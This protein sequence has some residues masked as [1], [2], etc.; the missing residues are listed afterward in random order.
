MQYISCFSDSLLHKETNNLVESFNSIVCKLVNGKRVNLC[1][2]NQYDTRVAYAIIQHNSQ[3][4]LMQIYV[5]MGKSVPPNVVELMH[6]RKLKIARTKQSRAENGRKRRHVFSKIDQNYGIMCEKPDLTEDQ[7]A[8]ARD[9][10]FLE[11]KE[12]QQNRVKIESDT[13]EQSQ[14]DLWETLRRKLLTASN[15][16]RICR[17]RPHTS[18]AATVKSLLFPSL[19]DNV[20]MTYGR[21]CE[22]IARKEI[23]IVTKLEIKPCG[24]F[25]DS[26]D[27]RF[28]ASPDGIID[29]DG[30]VEIKNPHR[31]QNLTAKEA[32]EKY[33][34][35]NFIDKK[36][37]GM[38]TTN[39]WYYQVQGQLHVTERNY[40]IFALRTPKSMEIRVVRRDDD[41]WNS[42]MEPFL[43]RFYENCLLPEI[44]DSRYLRNMQIRNPRYILDAKEKQDQKMCERKAK[45][46]NA[47]KKIIPDNLLMQLLETEKKSD[48]IS[49]AIKT[50]NCDENIE[51]SPILESKNEQVAK[52]AK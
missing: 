42:K 45:K 12:N 10:H 51:A 32:M 14:S 28:A 39:K 50:D 29:D 22:D 1:C 9:K 5:G 52:K 46:S 26:K 44:L 30:V 48:N 38:K 37:N 15:F 43:S 24:L 36:T 31:A 21:E 4:A 23:E 25:I 49:L 27:P 47:S 3:E 17:M 16:G 41:F 35:L 20:A 19:I 18:C 33:P 2:S 6:K 7:L 11:L 40:C 34:D 8:G 13:R